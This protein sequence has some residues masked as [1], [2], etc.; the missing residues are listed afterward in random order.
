M[1]TARMTISRQHSRSTPMSGCQRFDERSLGSNRHMDRIDRRRAACTHE[2]DST[3]LTVLTAG[4]AN[5]FV[6]LIRAA[7]GILVGSSA[8]LAEA[9]HSVADTL[10]QVFL[11]AS[12][13]RARRPADSEHPF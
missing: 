11:L 2:A 9:A 6:A 3:R 13:H 12:V 10:N 4:A 7:A 5:L 1:S 8:M